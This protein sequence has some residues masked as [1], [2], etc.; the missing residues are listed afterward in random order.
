[1]R[2]S[3]LSMFGS[4]LVTATAIGFVVLVLVGAI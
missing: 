1:V 3:N 2:A 4:Y